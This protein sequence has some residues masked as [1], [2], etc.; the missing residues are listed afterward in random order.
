MGFIQKQEEYIE[1]LERE[2][3]YCRD[4]LNNLLGKVKEV[5]S[6]NESLHDKQKN[7]LISSVMDH[8]SGIIISESDENDGDSTGIENDRKVII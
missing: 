8:R 4:E 3:S 1:Q 5:I 2:S 6:E 7:Q